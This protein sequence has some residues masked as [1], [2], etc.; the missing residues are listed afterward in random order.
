MPAV[1]PAQRWGS[2]VYCSTCG[3]VLDPGKAFCAI[4]GAPVVPRAGGPLA[5]PPPPPPYQPTPPQQL[6]SSY[7]PSSPPKPSHTVRNV[8]IL[9]VVIVVILAIVLA[10]ATIPSPHPFSEQINSAALF[11]SGTGMGYLNPPSDCQVKGSWHTLSGDAVIFG[12]MAA[13][14]QSVYSGDSASGSFS[15]TANDGPYMLFVSSS[16]NEVVDVS[17]DYW[18]ADL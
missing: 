15:F 11:G 10:V 12:I 7:Q 3:S 5:A 1:P 8:V 13:D 6:P 9:V 14:D 16:S 17:G 18:Y 2:S 4:C